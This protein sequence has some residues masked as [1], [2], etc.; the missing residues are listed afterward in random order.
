M[1]DEKVF[2]A[3]E[4]ESESS[5]TTSLSTQSPQEKPH[6]FAP[7]AVSQQDGPQFRRVRV[8]ANRFTPLR[9]KWAE[10]CQPIVEHMKLQIRMNRSKGQ[11]EIRVCTSIIFFSPARRVFG[12]Y[13]FINWVCGCVFTPALSTSWTGTLIHLENSEAEITPWENDAR[14]I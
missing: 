5:T 7:L 2:T 9:A 10:I 4:V 8:P 13:R 6:H 11:V 1:A 14:H 12:G 3:Q